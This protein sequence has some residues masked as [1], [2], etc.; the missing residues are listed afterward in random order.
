MIPISYPREKM[1][2]LDSAMIKC[3]KPTCR[4]KFRYKDY[5]EHYKYCQNICDEMIP[6]RR[7]KREVKE[8]EKTVLKSLN[9]KGKDF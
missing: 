1:K 3:Y 4:Q 9:I 2:I 7:I 5:K 6:L 8:A